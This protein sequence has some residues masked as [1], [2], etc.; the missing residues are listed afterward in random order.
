[1]KI[2]TAIASLVLS[3]ALFA[4]VGTSQAGMCKTKYYQPGWHMVHKCSRI[5][6]AVT[7]QEYNSGVYTQPLA[8]KGF[9]FLN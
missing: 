3:T 5:G 8:S 2:K 9:L 4:V 7:W 6:P 1:M